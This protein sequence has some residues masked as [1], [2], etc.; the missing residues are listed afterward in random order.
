MT[1]ENAPNGTYGTKMPGGK[2]LRGIFEPLAKRSIESYRKSGGTNRMS[3]MVGFPVVLLTTKGAKSGA[4]RTVTLGGFAE[5]GD[6]WLVVAS[7][8]GAA[9]HPAWFLNMVQ[10]PEDIWLEVGKEK[11]KVRGATLK[12]PEREEAFKR[13]AAISARYGT[14][15][16]K[17]DRTIPVVRLT[18]VDQIRT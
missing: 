18:R 10:H 3:R 15:P 12:G 14:Y 11:M 6:A 4:E 9:K 13:I 16:Q 17:T 2:L 7:N 5:G 1:I 8:G